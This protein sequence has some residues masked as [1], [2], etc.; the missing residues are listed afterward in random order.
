MT[1]LYR[2]IIFSLLLLTQVLP[3]AEI[4]ISLVEAPPSGNV[5]F[6][7]YDS[8]NAFGDLRDPVRIETAPLDGRETYIIT[9]VPPAEYALMVFYDENRNN[10]I[11]KNFIG[12]PNEPLGFSNEYQPKG[13]P[14]YARAAFTLSENDTRQFDVRLYRPLG[15]RGRIGIGPGLIW[16]SSPYRDYEGGV[17][18]F[19][20]SITYTGDRLQWFGPRV[21]FGLVGSG[22]LRLAATGTYRIGPY[23][24]DGSDYLAGMGDA[25]S[26]FMMGLA[27]Q[28]ELPGGLDLSLGGS[29]DVLDQIGGYEATIGLNKSFQLGICRLSP[30]IAVNWM[31]DHMAMNDYG[32]AS[33]EVRPGR[34][35][36]DPGAVFSVEGG[37]GLFIEITRDW[38]F[39]T[40]AAMEWLGAEASDSPIVE[41]DW[42]FKGF[43]AINYVF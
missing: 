33:N 1:Q 20:P 13:P 10:L 7:L 16:R 27:L 4:R 43:S 34:A 41:Q 29:A 3:A 12:I 24:E 28:A 5:V 23:E 14:S 22:K 18:Q 8:P 2:L 9:N 11:D 42:V 17:Y 19:I 25:E 32:V 39:V 15:R 21:Q 6:M 38:L 40:S 26:T 36:Y 31:D 37:I 30:E 35:A